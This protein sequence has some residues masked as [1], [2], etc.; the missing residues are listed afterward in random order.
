MKRAMRQ[1]SIFVLASVLLVGCGIMGEKGAA[2]SMNMQEAAEHADKMLD[3]TIGAIEPEVEWAHGDTTSGSCDLTRRRVVMTVISDQR[4][5]NFLGLI[6]R[7]WK[8]SGYKITSVK[9][10][11]THPAIFATS[12]QGFGIV[13][14]IRGEGQAHFEVNS[15]CVEKSKVAEPTTKPNGPAYEGVEIPRPNVHSDFWSA[16][17]PLSSARPSSS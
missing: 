16:D 12:P 5:G 15:P 10:G 3:S 8:K 6:E 1:V 13:L 17:T 11:K 9:E 2:A 4:R 14:A 7:F